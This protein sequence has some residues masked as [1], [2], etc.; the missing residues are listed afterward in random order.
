MG[1]DLYIGRASQTGSST[2][3]GE[4]VEEG[5]GRIRR[6]DDRRNGP[7]VSGDL[8]KAPS[9]SIPWEYSLRG[10]PKR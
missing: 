5:L 1:H 9:L 4:D 8:F 2:I 10:F 3:Q 7:Q 6:T